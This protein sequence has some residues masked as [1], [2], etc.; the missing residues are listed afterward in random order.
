M[1]FNDPFFDSNNF[2]FDNNEVAFDD[3]GITGLV[4]VGGRPPA[5]VP[6]VPAY[7]TLSNTRKTAR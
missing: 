2:G 3:I 4:G 5:I 6:W 1:P 7:G